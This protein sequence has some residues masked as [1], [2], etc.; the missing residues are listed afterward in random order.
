MIEIVITGLGATTP[1]GGDVASTWAGMLAGRSGVSAITEEWA[2]ELPVKIAAYVKVD[3]SEVG[4]TALL[5]ISRPVIKAHGS[6]DARALK[7][8]VLQ[9]I[10][11]VQAD[12]TNEIIKN[13]S[14]MT[15]GKAE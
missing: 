1:L 6:S 15:I 8:A 9:A 13:I 14:H 5:G 11:F 2:E 10:N 4:G 3:P 12:V 7:N